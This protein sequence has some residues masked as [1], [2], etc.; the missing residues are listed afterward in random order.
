MKYVKEFFAGAMDVDMNKRL[1]NRA[2]LEMFSNITM[3]HGMLVGHTATQGTSPVSWMAM[4]YKMKV[5][6]RPEMFSTIRVVTWVSG[7]SRVR[8]DREF[9]AYDEAGE[10]VAAASA[11]WIAI[12]GETGNPLRMTDELMQGFGPEEGSNFPGYKYM[13]P[14]KIAFEPQ[15]TREVGI[16]RSMADY[17]GHVHNSTYIEVAQEALPEELCRGTFDDIEI[18]YKN[19]IPIGG[20]VNLEYREDDG[21]CIIAIRDPE[22]GKLH[23][24]VAMGDH[25]E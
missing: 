24:A 20:K 9:V 2:L 25:K 12:D 22:D 8:A 21:V 4:N 3:Y 11:I 6:K 19:E 7:Y 13:N 14:R 23:G 18:A 16:H 5:M 17:N 10:T 15:T 1:T